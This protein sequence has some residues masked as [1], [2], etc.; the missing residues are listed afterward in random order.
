MTIA[1]KQAVP[2]STVREQLAAWEKPALLALLKD[3]YETNAENRDFM[4]ARCNTAEGHGVALEIYRAKIVEQ[5][6]PAKGHGQLMLSAARKAIRDYRK[7]TGNLLGAA[8]LL[9]TYVE[10]GIRFTQKYGYI[11]DGLDSSLLSALSELATLLRK[12]G[13]RYYPEVRERLMRMA[14]QSRRTGSGL[15]ECVQSILGQLEEELIGW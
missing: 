8:D 4:D 6:F 12:E 7:A 15:D 2:W 9:I 14:E 11:D 3:L 10:N 1:D 13:R 5:F